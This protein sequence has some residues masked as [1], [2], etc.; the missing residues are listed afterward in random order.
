MEVISMSSSQY[1]T[2]L[3][4]RTDDIQ[5]GVLLLLG[6]FCETT[7]RRQ[8]ETQHTHNALTLQLDHNTIKKTESLSP[9]KITRYYGFG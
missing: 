2:T 1:R 4:Y 9:E 3:L 6:T 7:D 8:S 5:F